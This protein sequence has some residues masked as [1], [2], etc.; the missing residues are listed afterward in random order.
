M[1]GNSTS[2]RYIDRYKFMSGKESYTGDYKY[3]CAPDYVVKDAIKLMSINSAY[4][5]AVKLTESADMFYAACKDLKEL[6]PTE[7]REDV[8]YAI[9]LGYQIDGVPSKLVTLL[10][11]AKGIYS[12]PNV[13][14]S[15]IKEDDLKV[16]TA[17]GVLKEGVTLT[18]VVCNV[19]K[20][21]VKIMSPY[22]KRVE[23]AKDVEIYVEKKIDNAKEKLFDTVVLMPKDMSDVIM[24]N[25]ISN[26]IYDSEKGI[27]LRDVILRTV[28]G[29]FGITKSD[30][31]MRGAF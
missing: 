16:F 14:L 15:M 6:I 21:D 26:V 3:V 7:Y 24:D 8:F 13:A 30:I 5:M 20:S 2:R 10:Q 17:P 31:D 4:Q 22:R 23:H 9:R 19:W 28:N 18:D 1:E 11:K 27:V 25:E 29:R 12:Y